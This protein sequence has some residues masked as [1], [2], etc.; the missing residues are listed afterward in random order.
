VIEELARRGAKIT[1]YDPV[2]MP[3][4]RRVFAAIE[5]VEFASD[6]GEALTGADALIVITEW[7]EFKSPDFDAIKSKLLQ[8][9]VVD[10]RNLYEPELMRALGIEYIGVG[11]SSG[12]VRTN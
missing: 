12:P 8:P 10:G 9:V 11:R 2:A 7:K 1:A 3:Q 4:A 5:G 6:Q